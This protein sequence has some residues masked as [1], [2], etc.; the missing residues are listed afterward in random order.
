MSQQAT[1]EELK[2]LP[3]VGETTAHV[4]QEKD[5]GS[6]E[7]IVRSTPMSLH[8]ECNIVLS[9]ATHIISASVQYLDGVCPRCRSENI[10]N[11]WQEYGAAIPDDNSI[12]IVCD[13]CGWYGGID[14]LE[15]KKDSS[16]LE[17]RQEESTDNLNK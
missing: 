6:F 5:Y 13:S 7:D 15:N 10:N 8:R 16:V 17:N 12:E 9:S 14:D 4:L 11:E 3:G 1:I 2:K